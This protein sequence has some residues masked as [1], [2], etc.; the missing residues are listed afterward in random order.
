VSKINGVPGESSLNNDW[1]GVVV[2]PALASVYQSCHETPN[3]RS[4]FE[5]VATCANGYIETTQ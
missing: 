5:L 4:I 3:D 2:V 1:V